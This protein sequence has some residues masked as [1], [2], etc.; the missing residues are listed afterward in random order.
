MLAPDPVPDSL[1]DVPVSGQP[2]GYDVH[3]ARA[4]LYAYSL[5]A[6]VV[7]EDGTAKGFA[8]H[9]LVQDFAWRETTPEWRAVALKKAISWV[10]DAILVAD[11]RDIGPSST[12]AA[13]AP[14]ATWL[15]LRG[16]EA[17]YVAL[18]WLLRHNLARRLEKRTL[19]LDRV[20]R[21]IDQVLKRTESKRIPESE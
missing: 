9:R 11:P 18:P 6:R 19:E 7:G 4:E 20:M 3:K 8:M 1:L 21:V 16:R 14:H 12:L 17:G 5:I 13:L 2:A 15:V 10:N